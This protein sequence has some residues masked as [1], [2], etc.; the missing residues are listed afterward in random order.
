MPVRPGPLLLQFMSNRGTLR[1]FKVARPYCGRCRRPVGHVKLSALSDG[2]LTVI[3]ACHGET[4]Q[5]IIPGNLLRAA[6]TIE[7]GIAFKESHDGSADN[8]AG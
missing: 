3:A 2:G 5:S 4:E 7:T 8:P 1:T 6:K